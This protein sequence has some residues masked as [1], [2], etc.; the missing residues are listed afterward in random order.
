MRDVGGGGL[1]NSDKINIK[2]EKVSKLIFFRIDISVDLVIITKK[3]RKYIKKIMLVS[4]LFNEFPVF[5]SYLYRNR[6]TL[7]WC[8]DLKRDKKNI[9]CTW[10]GRK[11]TG[12]P[13]NPFPK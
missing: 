9:G 8:V 2:N 12:I 10:A 3:E 1:Q 6:I 4:V 13:L 7:S 11:A 5:S